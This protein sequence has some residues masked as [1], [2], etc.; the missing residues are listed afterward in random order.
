MQAVLTSLVLN[1]IY[2]YD[3]WQTTPLSK[4]AYTGALKSISKCVL[5][6]VH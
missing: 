3:I 5:I 1:Y 4:A 6:V 2:I